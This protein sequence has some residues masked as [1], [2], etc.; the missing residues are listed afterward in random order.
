LRSVLYQLENE[1]IAQRPPVAL[2]SLLRTSKRL[3]LAPHVFHV[4]KKPA[5]LAEEYIMRLGNA[6]EILIY[7][8]R[9][10]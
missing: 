1:F 5:L 2:G 8:P 10:R 3:S 4:G 9:C 7:R 6:L